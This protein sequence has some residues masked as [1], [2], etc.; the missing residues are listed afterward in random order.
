MAQTKKT[1]NS[2]LG[3]KI[4][5]RCRHLPDLISVLDCY[6][7]SG[8]IWTGVQSKTQ[9]KIRRI[10]IDKIDYGVGFYLDGDNMAF[11][12]NAN[13]NKFTVIDLDAYGVPYEQLK[14]LF[15]RGYHGRVFVT[16]IQSL[17]GQMPI[18]LLEDIGFTHDMVSEIPTLFGKRGWQYFL[19]WLA[20]NGVRAVTHRSR[21]RKHYLTFD[22][23]DAAGSSLDYDNLQEDKVADH[24]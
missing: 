4:E 11:L 7:G 14:V 20:L 16:F 24:A 6:G 15:K 17:Y 8:A 9:R 12:Q 1:N 19:E 21:G 18:G 5:L 13:L 2:Y 3:N 22:I 23:N 10:G